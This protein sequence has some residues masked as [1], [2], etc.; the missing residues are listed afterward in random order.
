MF[1]AKRDGL[2]HSV[3][4]D[5]GFKAMVDLIKECRE[6]LVEDNQPG[7]LK[8]LTKSLAQTVITQCVMYM[9]GITDSELIRKFELLLGELWEQYMI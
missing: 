6:I 3:I 7:T 1:S 5:G 2:F 9:D 8:H 4:T